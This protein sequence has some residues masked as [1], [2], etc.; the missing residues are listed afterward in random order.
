MLFRTLLP[1]YEWPLAQP[2]LVHRVL[3]HSHHFSRFH[4]ALLPLTRSHHPLRPFRGVM[5]SVMA[6]STLVVLP[7]LDLPEMQLYKFVGDS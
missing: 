3:F 5:A 1:D 2:T 6:S 4:Q 7:P